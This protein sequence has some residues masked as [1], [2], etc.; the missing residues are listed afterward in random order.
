MIKFR[1]AKDFFVICI[2]TGIG[3]VPVLF[4]LYLFGIKTAIYSVGMSVS[5]LLVGIIGYFMSD[6]Y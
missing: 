4:L 5:V 1:T 2:V 3:F 6:D